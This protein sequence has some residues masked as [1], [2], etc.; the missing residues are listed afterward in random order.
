MLCVFTTC[1]VGVCMLGQVKRND[2]GIF[3]FHINWGLGDKWERFQSEIVLDRNEG[4][5]CRGGEEGK[6]EGR[7]GVCLG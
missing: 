1:T 3:F 6:G 5:V 4:C 7:N 2:Q